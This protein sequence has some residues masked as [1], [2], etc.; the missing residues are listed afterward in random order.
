MTIKDGRSNTR[1]RGFNG[2][3]ALANLN[4]QEIDD[5]IVYMRSLPN[6]Q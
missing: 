1:M 4:D 6:S 5:I 3:D 2:P